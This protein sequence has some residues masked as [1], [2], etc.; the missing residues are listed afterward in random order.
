MSYLCN[1]TGKRFRA[2]LC[3]DKQVFPH[4]CPRRESFWPND[5]LWVRPAIWDMLYL[6]LPLPFPVFSVLLWVPGTSIDSLPSGLIGFGQR[7]HCQE[8]K[9]WENH[10]SWLYISL[11]PCSF[12][13][14]Q[15]LMASRLSYLPFLALEVLTIITPLFTSDLKVLKPPCQLLTWVCSSV[16]PCFCWTF[17]TSF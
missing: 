9:E 16:S 2:S 13:T 8:I 5:T 10:D 15:R 6:S 11:S 4:S 14:Y 7:R 17:L 1:V 12:V 3:Q